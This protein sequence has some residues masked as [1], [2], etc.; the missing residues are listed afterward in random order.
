MPADMRQ[1]FE[2]DENMQ[3]FERDGLILIAVV[4]QTYGTSDDDEWE[5]DRELFR[6]S[7][8]K[9]FG[10]RFEDGNIGPGAD[11]PAFVTLVQAGLHVP[12]W[13]LASSIFFLGKPLRDNFDAWRDIGQRLRPFF[14]FPAYLNRQGAAVIAV[15]ALLDELGGAPNELQLLSYRIVHIGE[16]HDLTEYDRFSEIADALPTLYLGFIRHV[17]E[18]RADGVIFRIGVDGTQSE[19]VKIT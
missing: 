14:K 10:Q 16:E 8:E 7:L 6:L 9:E 11:L 2:H 5:R 17:F 19:L 15:E 12:Y 1:E 4:D 3:A 18:I 13:V